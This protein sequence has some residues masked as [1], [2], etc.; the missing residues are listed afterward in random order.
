MP[1]VS[2]YDDLRLEL[3]AL[4]RR[5][6]L[7]I[8]PPAAVTALVATVSA[9]NAYTA[10][11]IGLVT[12]MLLPLT[13]HGL[14]RLVVPRYRTLSDRA[15]KTSADM[16]LLGRRVDDIFEGYRERRKGEQ[17]KQAYDLAG[18]PLRDLEEA[19]SVGMFRERR[20][21]FVTAFMRDGVAVRVTASIGSPFRCAAG[22]DPARW[23]GH[24][25]RLGCDEVRQYHNHP[26][27]TGHT[28]PSRTDIRT[29]RTLAAMLGPHGAKL[30]SMILCWNG[31]REWRVFEYDGSG[32]HRLHFEFDAAMQPGRR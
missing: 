1:A 18:R 23:A 30:R 16:T 27:H 26:V 6:A 24:V 4:R 32:R 28:R 31:V 5:Q 7:A 21:V 19:L 3:A 14:G 20:E 13:L 10:V 17:F 25:E 15:S 8:L 9:D 11:V 12:L 29:A 22:D 2:R